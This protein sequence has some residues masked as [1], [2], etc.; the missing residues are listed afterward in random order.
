MFGVVGLTLLYLNGWI[1]QIIEGDPSNISVVIFLLFLIGLFLTG[2][3][4]NKL[5][6][7]LNAVRTGKSDRLKQYLELFHRRGEHVASE[8]TQIRLYSKIQWIRR[9]A[10]ALVAIGLVGTV[11]GAITFLL[12]I[13]VQALGDISTI[14]SAFEVVLKGMGTALYTTLVG[15]VLNLWLTFNF[16]IVENGTSDLIAALMDHDTTPK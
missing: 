16:G 2:F 4:V 14:G 6:K 5:T 9:I 1:K 7:E 13:N 11:V 10:S 8:V 12:G 15:A 3:R